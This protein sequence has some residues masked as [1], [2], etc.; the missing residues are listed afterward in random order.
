MITSG[1]IFRNERRI[2]YSRI[3]NIDAVQNLFHRL[4]GVVEV[5]VETGGGDTP[6]ASLRVLPRGALDEM[7]ERVFAG[8]GR[9]V[10][11][12]AEGAVSAVQE[13]RPELLLRL[14]TRELLLAGFI[15][16][17]GLIIIMAAFGLVAVRNF[18]RRF[19]AA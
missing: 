6:E 11:P 19:A 4:F 15:E 8:R 13:E 5:R 3:Q 7:R 14:R 10:V 2:P 1:L 18:R 17:R 9:A 12:A 16:S